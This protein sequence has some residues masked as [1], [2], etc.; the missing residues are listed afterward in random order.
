MI[1]TLIFRHFRAMA[2]LR[3]RKARGQAYIDDMK[4][5]WVVQKKW[6]ENLHWT[7]DGHGHKKNDYAGFNLFVGEEN[8]MGDRRIRVINNDLV[9]DG[10]ADR[11]NGH[12]RLKETRDWKEAVLWRERLED[13]DE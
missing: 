2:R 6:Q 11:N 12:E 9:W 7:N 13:E 10:K 1:L 5:A 4:S 3:A 8:G